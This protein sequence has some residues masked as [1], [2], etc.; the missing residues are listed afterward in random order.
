MKYKNKITPDEINL[1]PIGRFNG[2]ILLIDTIEKY[3]A[4]KSDLKKHK[5]FG[6]DTESRPAFKKGIV[7]KL[8]LIQLSTSDTA[9][10]F[11][12][13]L[14]GIPKELLKIFQNE[15]VIKVGLA[16]NDDV[17]NIQKLFK[18]KPM[19]FFELK[20]LSKLHGI[21]DFSLK[22]LAAII[23][24]IKISKSNQLSNWEAEKLSE[25]QLVYAATDAWLCFEM[26]KKLIQTI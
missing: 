19:G 3:N 21:E 22:K 14:I 13:N 12:I 23:M 25:S 18:F 9:Y 6:F 11:R 4:I 16:V 20:N 17:K 2:K 10:I 15:N 1:L 5:L 24:N 26:Y 8:A 7:N